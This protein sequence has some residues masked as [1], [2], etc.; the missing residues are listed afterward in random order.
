MSIQ[1]ASLVELSFVVENCLS[2]ALVEV[3]VMAM[4]SQNL[5][6]AACVDLANLE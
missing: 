6:S 4:G 1:C 2:S 5:V 3:D